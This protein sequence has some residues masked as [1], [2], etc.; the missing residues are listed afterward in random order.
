MKRL[1]RMG[2]GM[3]SQKADVVAVSRLETRVDP[4]ARI[5]PF[6]SPTPC[7]WDDK[8]VI[9]LRQRGPRDPSELLLVGLSCELEP[10]SMGVEIHDEYPVA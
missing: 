2:E 8:E 6:T 7:E 5:P 4:G 1:G 9:P 3:S 10:V